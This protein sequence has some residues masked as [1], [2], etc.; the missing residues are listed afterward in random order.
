MLAEWLASLDADREAAQL[1]IID[2]LRQV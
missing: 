1:M 2:A